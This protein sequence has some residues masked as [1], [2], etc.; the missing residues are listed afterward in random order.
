[1][2]IF[3]TRTFDHAPGDGE[4]LD[5]GAALVARIARA[6]EPLRRAVESGVLSLCSAAGAAR[7]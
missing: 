4:A 7:A 5:D 1:M 6:S 2:S 3:E